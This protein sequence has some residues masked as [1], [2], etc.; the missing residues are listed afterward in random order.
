LV[1]RGVQYKNIIVAE[2]RRNCHAN[3]NEDCT[4]ELDY[5]YPTAFEDEQL[6]QKMKEML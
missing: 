1:E 5:I 6:L 4:E 2:P 3:E